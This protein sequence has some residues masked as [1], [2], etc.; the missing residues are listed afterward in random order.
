MTPVPER[1]R[2]SMIRLGSDDSTRA[3]CSILAAQAFQSVRYPIL[4]TVERHP[5]NDPAGPGC[6]EELLHWSL[7]M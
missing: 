2:R 7:R 1:F 5:A 3:I 4:A 6:V